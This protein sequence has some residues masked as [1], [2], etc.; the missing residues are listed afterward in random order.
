MLGREIKE[1]MD[2]FAGKP[3]NKIPFTFSE[4]DAE[5]MERFQEQFPEHLVLVT[6][7][8]DPIDLKNLRSTEMWASRKFHVLILENKTNGAE[9]LN[10]Y[11][12]EV[13]TKSKRWRDGISWEE[14]QELK[15]QCGRGDKI[16]F[17]PFPKDSEVINT[18]NI[19]HL[20]IAKENSSIG[21]GFQSI[22]AVSGSPK[23]IL[24]SPTW[25]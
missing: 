8:F 25:Q 24:K 19:R 1:F 6:H 21:S 4:E 18:N 20:F 22:S 11:R 15:K 17:E 3:F 7:L 16:A 14:M 5:Y 12:A 9:Q 10:I 2:K 23:N 13:D